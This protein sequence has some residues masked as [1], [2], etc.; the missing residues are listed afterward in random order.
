MSKLKSIVAAIA[1]SDEARY[2]AD[3]AAMVPK[4]QHAPLCLLHGISDA[5][6][7]ALHRLVRASTEAKAKLVDDA[8]RM[9]NVLAAD[10]GRHA[11][12][13]IEELLLGSVR[14]HVLAG[15]KCDVPVVHERY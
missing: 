11:L 14:R 1:F 13:M 3:R 12:F 9:L 15:S 5:S 6:L 10:I 2:M 4:E 8:R 7:N